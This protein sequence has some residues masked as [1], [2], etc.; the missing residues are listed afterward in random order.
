MSLVKALTSKD[1]M[2]GDTSLIAE[3]CIQPEKIEKASCAADA[4]DVKPSRPACCL[5]SKSWCWTDKG[6]GGAG[7][8]VPEG[9]IEGTKQC[10]QNQ[11]TS[12]ENRT[13]HAAQP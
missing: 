7:D 4:P 12:A 13:P 8:C 5:A 3:S 10:S 2:D 1:K 6:N 9:T 11:W